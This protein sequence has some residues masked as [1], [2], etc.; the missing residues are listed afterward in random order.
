MTL[1]ELPWLA[2]RTAAGVCSLFVSTHGLWSIYGLDFRL[3][4]LISVLYCVLPFLSFFVFLFVKTPRFEVSLHA[5]I[6]VGYL[7]TYAFL[8][9]RTCTAFGYC[10]TVAAT[11]GTTLTTR[12]MLAACAVVLLRTATLLLDARESARPASPRAN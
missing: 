11:I 10:T 9:W 6:A 5:F 2:L 3:D 7:A 4:T 8:N 1:R 12:P